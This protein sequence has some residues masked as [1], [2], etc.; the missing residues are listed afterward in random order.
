MNGDATAFKA[1]G[2]SSNGITL[3]G[4]TKQAGFWNGIGFSSAN[5]NNELSGVTLEYAGGGDLYTFIEGTAALQLGGGSKVS[6]TNSTFRNSDAYGIQANEG[7]EF[8]DFS[9]NTFESNE[10]T[11]MNVQAGNIGSMDT[12]TSYESYVRVYGGHISDQTLTVSPID[13]PYRVAGVRLIQEGSDVTVEA[14]TTFEFESNGGLK[15]NG[16]ATAFKA[17][18]AE[19]DSIVFTGETKQAGYWEGLGFDSANSTNE[20][21]HVKVEYGGGGELYTFIGDVANIQVLEG[22]QLTLENSL[23]KDSADY[24]LYADDGASAVSESNN[25]YQDNV[26]GGTNY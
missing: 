4:V 15:V 19:A 18:G 1:Q 24:G 20:L 11:S 14:G 10:R 8:T 2:T 9:D 5:V 23:I 7:V 12:G 22:A 3:T 6:I 25:T 16:D 26:S 17:Q 13:V 21:S